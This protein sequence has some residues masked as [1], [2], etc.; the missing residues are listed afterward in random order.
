LQLD[1]YKTT[2][3]AAMLSSSSLISCFALAAGVWAASPGPD[4]WQLLL[5]A[6]CA[7][8]MSLSIFVAVLRFTDG[9]NGTEAPATSSQPSA[10]RILAVAATTLHQ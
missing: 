4:Q 9:D 8:V 6:I 1:D 5:Q 2:K 10:N 3:E 7:V